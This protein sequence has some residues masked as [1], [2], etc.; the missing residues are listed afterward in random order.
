METENIHTKKYYKIGEV[1]RMLGLAA[2]TLRFWETEF[3]QLKPMKNKKGDRIY[4]LKDIEL[5][6]EIHYLTREKGIKIAKATRKISGSGSD[7]EPK[8]ALVKKLRELKDRLLVFQKALG[9]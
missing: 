6:K 5:L 9:R 3:R 1:S 2:S 7:V 4:S 8:A